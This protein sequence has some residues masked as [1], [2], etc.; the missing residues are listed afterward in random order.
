MAQNKQN[1]K[2]EE[3]ISL[4]KSSPQTVFLNE[5]GKEISETQYYKTISIISRLY[6]SIVYSTIL[7]FE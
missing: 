7:L 3:N 4:N 5:Q 1:R 2:I 6:K